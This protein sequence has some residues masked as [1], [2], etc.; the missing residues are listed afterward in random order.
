MCTASGTPGT[1][2]TP[3][4]TEGSAPPPVYPT[5]K[6]NTSNFDAVKANSLDNGILAEQNYYGIVEKVIDVSEEQLKKD[7]EKK[8]D[9]RDFFTY[10]FSYFI[11]AQFIVLLALMFLNSSSEKF[12]ISDALLTT[13]IISVFVETLGI[14]AAMVAFVFSSE[15]EVKIIDIL[16][17]VI[18]NYQ[19]PSK[20][21]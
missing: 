10:F 21:D 20:K 18:A 14:I 9:L 4:Q 12:N 7:G 13:Y 11:L 8:R 15:E 17:A 19:K 16:N 6:I 1:A 3:A 2:N 5:G